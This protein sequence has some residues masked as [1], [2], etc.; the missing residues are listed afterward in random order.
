[1]LALIHMAY[2]KEKKKKNLMGQLSEILSN[3]EL[4]HKIVSN[5]IVHL[6]SVWIELILLKLKIETENTVIK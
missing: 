1:M 2:L 6:Q 4:M 3:N 5:L